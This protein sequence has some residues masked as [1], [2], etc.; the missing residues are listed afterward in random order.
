MQLALRVFM[1]EVPI[2]P[3]CKGGEGALEPGEVP[4]ERVF[5]TEVAAQSRKTH[6]QI[7]STRSVY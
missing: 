4:P 3:P 5:R 7:T 6:D 1:R 2:C